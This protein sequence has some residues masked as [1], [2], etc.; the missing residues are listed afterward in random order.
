MQELSYGADNMTFRPSPVLHRR[1]GA[2]HDSPRNHSYKRAP[3]LGIIAGSRMHQEVDIYADL[4]D[5]KSTDWRWSGIMPQVLRRDDSKKEAR[6]RE[7]R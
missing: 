4:S 6:A 1:P 7:R 3:L 2:D 5:D